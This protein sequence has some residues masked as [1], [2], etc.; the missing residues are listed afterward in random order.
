LAT[1]FLLLVSVSAYALCGVQHRP[2]AGADATVAAGAGSAALGTTTYPIPADATFVA[3]SGSDASGDGTIDN[4]YATLQHALAGIGPTGG[5]V[6]LR[7]GDYHED[8][9][10]TQPD[11]TIQSYPDE[12]VELDG[13]VPVA[14]WAQVGASWVHSGWS[15]RFDH[16]QSFT[17]GTNTPGFVNSAHPMA[18]W[19]DE[20]FMDGTQLDQ[21]AASPG[22]GQFSVDYDTGTLTVGSDPQGHDVRASDLSQAVVS[23]GTDFTLRGIEILGYATSLPQLGAVYISGS[24]SRLEN[25][26]VADIATEAVSVESRSV[27]DHLTVLD[28]GM[29]GIHGNHAN[30]VVIENSDVEYS[31]RE[32]FGTAP[33]AGGIKITQSTDVTV[34]G[35]VLSNNFNATGVWL[36]E[37]VVGFTITDNAAENDGDQAGSSGVMVELSSDG[38]VS[39]NILTGSAHGAYLLDSSGVRVLDDTF[40][41]NGVGSVFLSQDGRSIAPT[42]GPTVQPTAPNPWLLRDVAVYANRFMSNGGPLGYQVYALDSKLGTP[43]SSMNIVIDGNA[44]HTASGATDMMV[45]WGQAD[46]RTVIAYNTPAELNAALGVDWH[47][48]QGDGS[49]TGD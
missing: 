1:V 26:I 8:I 3:T 14:G 11:V 24:G 9:A 48:L 31:N 41:A 10:V 4:P 29:T 20:L 28:A 12:A 30:G 33:S 42:A 47:N 19:P 2:T 25:D 7:G 36:D 21:V 6:I 44:F 38:I 13:T 35:N 22:A 39:G 15:A 46:C 18:A 16:S 49:I 5:T 45:G 23:T 43:A 34:T 32:H 40:G 27:L 17:T 37:N